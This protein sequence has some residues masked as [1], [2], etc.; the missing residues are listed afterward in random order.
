MK[1]DETNLCL[2]QMQLSEAKCEQPEPGGELGLSSPVP[3][4]LTTYISSSW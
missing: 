2:S 4:A 1:K 3:I